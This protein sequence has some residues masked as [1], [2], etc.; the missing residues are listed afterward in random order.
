[1]ISLSSG[2]ATMAV[3]SPLAA[4]MYFAGMPWYAC[5]MLGTAG[6]TVC[7]S[8][9]YLLYRLGSKAIDK[10]V[11][12][13]VPELMSVLATEFDDRTKHQCKESKA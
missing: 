6:M 7:V 11:A 2:S 12:S 5:V 1:M 8:H 3:M 13:R 10:T 4:S 9:Q